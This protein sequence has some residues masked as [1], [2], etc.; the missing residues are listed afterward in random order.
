MDMDILIIVLLP[1]CSK[2]A[3]T[4]ALTDGAEIYVASAGAE[5]SESEAETEAEDEDAA[6][7]ATKLGGVEAEAWQ[8]AQLVARSVRLGSAS[9]LGQ[10][11]H[12]VVSLFYHRLKGTAV[13]TLGG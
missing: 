7:P 12:Q 10:L 4:A 1:C 9:L 3:R 11:V 8:E 2:T 5:A 6:A 13:T